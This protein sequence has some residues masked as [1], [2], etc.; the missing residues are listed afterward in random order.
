MKSKFIYRTK[1]A[2]YQDKEWLE[3]KYWEEELSTYQIGKICEVSKTT[4]I[5]WFK[6]FDI[7]RRSNLIAW[8]KG[9]PVSEETKKKLSES[10]KGSKSYRWKG[11]IT[12]LN[13]LIRSNFKSRQWRSDVF[14]RDDFTCQE[15]GERG[16]KLNAHHIKSYSSILQLY[17]ITTI[18]EAL[19]CEELW[20]INNGI[21]YCEKCHK[22][23]ELHKGIKKTKCQNK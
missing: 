17:E 6:K 2:I 19:E 18:E 15:C 14:T 21:T 10:H 20:N 7:S 9:I 11:G 8:N 12:L 22:K 23:K 16:G 4:I 13:H 5:R 1:N 3:K